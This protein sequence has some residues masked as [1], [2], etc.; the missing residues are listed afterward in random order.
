MTGW[1]AAVGGIA[2]GAGLAAAAWIGGGALV[3]ARQPPRVV[4]VKGLAERVVEADVAAWRIAFRGEGETQ[5]QAI[6]E[7]AQA[8]SAVRAF[9]LQGGVAEDALS[10]EPFTLRVDR[11]YL[12]QGASERLRFTAAGALRL[13]TENVAAVA[14]LAGRTLDLLQAGVKIGEADYA[15]APRPLFLF[16]GINAIKP[17]MIADATQSAREAADQFAADS[18]A[19]VGEIVSANQGV[20]QFLARDGDYPEAQER[21]K[22]VRVVST[23]DYRLVD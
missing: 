5:A 22:I 11:V 6:A 1:G 2:V 17:G 23:V 20:V 9:A 12:D 16:T 19:R 8:A 13:R 3:E 15:E 14:E 7:A 21:W 18:G 10:D 4:T